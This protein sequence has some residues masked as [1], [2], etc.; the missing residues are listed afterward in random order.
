MKEDKLIQEWLVQNTSAD[1]L[2]Q[3]EHAIAITETLDTPSKTT[4]EDAWANLLSNINEESTSNEKVLTPTKKQDKSWMVWIAG[5]A[6]LFVLGY[7]GLMDSP[8]PT[9]YSTE[10]ANTITHSLPDQ[11]N[12]TMNA[13]SSIS[14]IEDNWE[15]ERM[16]SLSGEAFFEVEPG[17]KFTIV[18]DLGQ[19]SVLGTSFNVFARDNTLQVSTFTG[20]V[21]VE[22]GNQ[23]VIL[24]PGDQLTLDVGKDLWKADSFNLNQTATWRIGSFYYDLTPLQKVVDELERQFAIKINVSTDISERIY[25]GYFSRSDLEEALQLVFLPMGFNF[26]VDGNQVNIQ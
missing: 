19:V 7:F 9:I 17:S 5:I 16:L 13:S 8:E 3:L 11:S 21:K 26:S 14:F 2:A 12:V 4:K 20:K 24:L 25:S 23:N 1:D 15:K 18:T 22:K 6:A 10:L